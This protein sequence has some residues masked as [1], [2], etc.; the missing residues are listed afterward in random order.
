MRRE[1]WREGR[2]GWREDTQAESKGAV[3]GGTLSY[4][5][6]VGSLEPLIGSVRLGFAFGFGLDLGLGLG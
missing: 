2:D 3:A 4:S 5:P 6:E 1:G